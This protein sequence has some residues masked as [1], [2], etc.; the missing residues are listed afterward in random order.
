MDPETNRFVRKAPNQNTFRLVPTRENLTQLKDNGG[1]FI[2]EDLSLDSDNNLVLLDLEAISKNELSKFNL[3]VGDIIV[4][5]YRNRNTLTRRRSG[6]RVLDLTKTA[7]GTSLG[8]IMRHVS[9]GFCEW[10]FLSKMN[11]FR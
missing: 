6:V 1:N 7:G 10:A 11:N 2:T 9:R 5:P 8:Q 3:R 4:T